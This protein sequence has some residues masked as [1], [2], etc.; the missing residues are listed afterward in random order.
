MSCSIPLRSELEVI[1][2]PVS[3]SDAGS[4][5]N[6]RDSILR[7][8]ITWFLSLQIKAYKTTYGISHTQDLCSQG[9]K[10]KGDGFACISLTRSAKFFV[11]N[12]EI[13]Y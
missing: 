4:E 3:F 9:P 1:S 8:K 11:Q 5:C 12:P 2:N 10:Y 13:S 6:E 7:K